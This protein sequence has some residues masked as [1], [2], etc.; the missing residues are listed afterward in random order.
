MRNALCGLLF[1]ACIAE[2]GTLN[3]AWT[4]PTTNEDGTALTDLASYDVFTRAHKAKQ[5]V[6]KTVQALTPAPAEGS[7][8][9]YK[10]TKVPNGPCQWFVMAVDKAGQRSQPS[11][12]QVTEVK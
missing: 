8:V 7:I 10:R 2:A 4:E 9:T 1:A 11:R 5:W 12:L 6:V 3:L